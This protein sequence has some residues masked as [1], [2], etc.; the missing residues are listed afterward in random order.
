MTTDVAETPAPSTDEY[1]NP[2]APQ[3]E[4]AA[5]QE[6]ASEAAQ[7]EAVAEAT[8]STD[9]TTP[10]TEGAT[11][12]ADADAEPEALFASELAK[13]RGTTPEEQAQ[14]EAETKLPGKSLEDVQAENWQQASG[15]Y[16]QIMQLA[17]NTE[18]QPFL[19]DE[20]GLAPSE[21]QALWQRVRPLIQAVHANNEAHNIQTTD[22]LVKTL[23]SPEEQAE[24]D[25]RSYDVREN[26]VVQP[27]S[28]RK[29]R[30]EAVLALREKRVHDEYAAKLQSGELLTKAEA[31]KVATAMYNRGVSNEQ[32]GKTKARSGQ[33]VATGAPTGGGTTKEEFVAMSLENQA[34]FAR[35]HPEEFAALQ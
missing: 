27:L 21:A 16:A 30:L 6:Q 18:V 29:A 31:E 7:Q 10:E 24:Y 14:A 9:A 34:R 3:P 26:G 28:S 22:F 8:P 5:L 17:D 4:E 11:A 12:E 35:E 13:L 25:K 19:R 32:N 20:L 23:L 1:E 15:V 2:F 33:K